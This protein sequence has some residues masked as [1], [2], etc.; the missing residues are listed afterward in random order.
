MPDADG[1]IADEGE[2]STSAGDR[3]FVWVLDP[4]DGTNNCA[5]GI[6]PVGAARYEAAPTPF[7][8]SNP[9]SHELAVTACRAVLA[10]QPVADRPSGDSPTAE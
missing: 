5:I 8:A 6:R 10:A 9:S 7:L 4:L 1:V 2:R 3:V